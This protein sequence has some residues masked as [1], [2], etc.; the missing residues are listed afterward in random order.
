MREKQAE[1]INRKERKEN[2]K[3]FLMVD[4]LYLLKQ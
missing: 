4:G 1:G 2:A 3:S